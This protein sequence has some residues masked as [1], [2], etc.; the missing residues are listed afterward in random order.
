VRKIERGID[1]LKMKGFLYDANAISLHKAIAY[2]IPTRY[3]G[4]TGWP[5]REVKGDIRKQD[6]KWP[7]N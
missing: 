3:Y 6:I 4:M 7:E 5:I 2:I 1:G